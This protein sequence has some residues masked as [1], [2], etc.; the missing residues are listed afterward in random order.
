ML[1]S[2]KDKDGKLKKSE[3]TGIIL[4]QFDKL[5]RNKDGF[6]DLD[7]LIVFS[8]W[9]NFHHKPGTPPVELNPVP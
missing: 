8:D 7:E 3:A 1:A 9:L 2:D 6:L 4:P 5:D